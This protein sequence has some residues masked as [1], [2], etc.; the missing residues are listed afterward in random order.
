M[1]GY[2]LSTSAAVASTDTSI[3]TSDIILME[4]PAM[5]GYLL[6]LY[7]S[8]SILSVISIIVKVAIKSIVSILAVGGPA[9][10]HSAMH[11]YLSATIAPK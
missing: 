8:I 10:E 7:C 4:H 1:Q 11:E 3:D 9:L 5:Q 6:P 2:L